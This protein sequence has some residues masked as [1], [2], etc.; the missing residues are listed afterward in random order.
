MKLDNISKEHSDVYKVCTK[1]I[2]DTSVPDILFNEY[3][4]FIQIFYLYHA[5]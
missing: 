4:Y 3:G 5:I 1:C 2:M